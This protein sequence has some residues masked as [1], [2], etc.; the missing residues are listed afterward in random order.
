MRRT[1]G[2]AHVA[3]T[4]TNLTASTD[5]YQRIFDAT[6]AAEDK[7]DGHESVVLVSPDGLVIGLHRHSSTLP[8]DRFSETR[9]GLDH[10]AFSCSSRA[11]VEEWQ[12]KL[13]LLGITHSGVVGSPFGFHLNFRDPDQIPLEFFAATS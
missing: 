2:F 4:V 3:L 11:E 6:R 9:V 12:I 10:V 13:E 5:W 1:Q 7:V 8:D